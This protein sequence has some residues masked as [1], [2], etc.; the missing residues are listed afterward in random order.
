MLL[1]IYLAI[2]PGRGEAA[3]PGV[4][5]KAVFLCS[6]A[7]CPGGGDN[8]CGRGKGPCPQDSYCNPAVGQRQGIWGL[9]RAAKT[10]SVKNYL[11]AGGPAGR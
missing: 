4:A 3:V 9:G 1:R 2:L 8:P 11:P 7:D 6:T 10:E 5:K